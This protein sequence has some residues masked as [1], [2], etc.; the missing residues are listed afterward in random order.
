[1]IFPIDGFAGKSDGED[2]FYEKM[3][4]FLPQNF[5]SYH[6]HDIGMEEADVIMLVPNK[7]VLVIE[8]KAF[9]PHNINKA[10]DNKYILKKNGE[11]IF[12]PF[13]QAARYRDLLVDRLRNINPEYTKYVIAHV[14]CFTHFTKQDLLEKEMG[15][16]CDIDLFINSEDII[17][18]EAFSK[19]LEYIF[20]CANKLNISG[21]KRNF[22]PPDEMV[23][24]GNIVM[25][26]SVS[27]EDILVFEDVNEMHSNQENSD[28]SHVYV[29]ADL[30][31]ET[32][33]ECKK[34][35]QQWN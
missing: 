29:K 14:P 25:P 21:L 9:R 18:F 33:E 2:L 10:R 4:E 20:E 28:Y 26:S 35:I 24:V 23:L 27:L 7:G 13:K 12:S 3:N 34:I 16:I 15:K 11:V 1:M 19:R 32:D 17:S 31:E 8:I 30:C 5:I 22:F 6:N